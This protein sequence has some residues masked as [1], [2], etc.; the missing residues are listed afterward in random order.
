MEGLII[1]FPWVWFQNLYKPILY[2]YF[3]VNSKPLFWSFLWCPYLNASLFSVGHGLSKVLKHPT[4]HHQPSPAMP[5]RSQ[6]KC[7]RFWPSGHSVESQP[8]TT[9]FCKLFSSV[10]VHRCA[11]S[12]SSNGRHW[13]WYTDDRSGDVIITKKSKPS[14]AAAI[15]LILP[16][17]VDQLRSLAAPEIPRDLSWFNFYAVKPT[18]LLLDF[19]ALL[20]VKYTF[21]YHAP[22]FAGPFPCWF[23]SNSQS[24]ACFTVKTRLIDAPSVVRLYPLLCWQPVTFTKWYI[25]ILHLYII[26]IYYIYI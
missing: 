8:S 16:S 10:E 24:V 1:F 25:Y 9:I 7:K 19:Q 12:F 23:L 17:I 3:F 20:L 6:R 18:F 5:R 11:T 14:L 2:W 13:V 15:F 26:F 4:D 21:W 22:P